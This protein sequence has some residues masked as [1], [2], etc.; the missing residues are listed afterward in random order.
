MVTVKCIRCGGAAIGSSFAEASTKI[1]H[2]VGLS[3]G[4]K[5]GDNYGQVQEVKDTTTISPPKKETP[6]VDTI[7]ETTIDTVIDTSKSYTKEKP[8]AKEK[9]K[10]KKE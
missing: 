8:V 1:N 4:V 3:R 7:I 2:A 5:C 6:T 9:S 10:S